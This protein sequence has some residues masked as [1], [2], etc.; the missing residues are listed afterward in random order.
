MFHILILSLLNII[1]FFEPISAFTTHHFYRA[2][3]FPEEP[4]Y[5]TENLSTLKVR[6][7]GGNTHSSFD[8]SGCLNDLWAVDNVIGQELSQSGIPVPFIDSLNGEFQLFEA[9]LNFYQNLGSNFFVELY[10]PIR[11]TE[12]TTPV[13]ILPREKNILQKTGLADTVLLLGLTYDYQETEFFDFIDGSIQT[14]VLFPTGKIKNKKN[15]F[16]FS[17]GYGGHYG[18]P[19]VLDLSI[20]VF[21]WVT[22]GFHIDSVF[23]LKT[24]RE[25]KRV[26]PC[27]KGNIASVGTYLKADH[28][29]KGISFG[30][31]F[32]HDRKSKNHEY[33]YDP[34]LAH[35][36]MTNF[37][38]FFEYDLSECDT[39]LGP[40]IAF[41]YNTPLSGK[42]IFRNTI[43]G[44]EITLDAQWCF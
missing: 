11:Q 25:S 3:F 43:K 27:I 41:I 9:D 14:G 8:C 33:T 42:R 2:S 31:G 13:S 38:F 34:A 36:S 22:L 21:D 30:L 7:A 17:Y 39:W 23:L 16:D 4:R 37:H 28:I 5:A 29:F 18:I 6:L 19:I 26:L 1:F 44:A 32:S 40:R 15:I 10:L 24:V 12:I 20:G 35:W